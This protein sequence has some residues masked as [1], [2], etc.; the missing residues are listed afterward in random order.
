MNEANNMY[1]RGFSGSVA[2]KDRF[3][4]RKSDLKSQSDME[5]NLRPELLDKLNTE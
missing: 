3:E 4:K 5:S 1:E 2:E